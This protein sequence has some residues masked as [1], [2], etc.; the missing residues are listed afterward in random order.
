MTYHD[1]EHRDAV[2]ERPNPD[3]LNV[4]DC[5]GNNYLG[6]SMTLAAIVLLI[7]GAVLL[8]PARQQSASVETPANSTMTAP[9]IPSP[10]PSAAP[11][12][13]PNG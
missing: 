2:P 12:S 9:Q 4:P 11:S 13:R 5:G 10:D 7:V 3:S 8:T 1:P 6:V